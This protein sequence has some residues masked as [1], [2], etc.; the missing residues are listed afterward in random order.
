MVLRE[1]FSDVVP[2]NAAVTV[3]LARLVPVSFVVVIVSRL[4]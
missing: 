1:L 2:L 4:L 3:R